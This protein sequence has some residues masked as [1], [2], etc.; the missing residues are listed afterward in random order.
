MQDHV[1]SMSSRITQTSDELRAR[2][3]AAQEELEREQQRLRTEAQKLP[4]ATRESVDSMRRMLAEQMRA[5]DQVQ[6]IAGR[7][8]T[9]ISPPGPAVQQPAPRALP[10]AQPSL[11]AAIAAAMPPPAQPSAAPATG[12]SVGDLLARAS[13]EEAAQPVAEPV[14]QRGPDAGA[15]INLEQIAT[16]LDAQTAGAIWTR[17]RSGQRGILVRSIYTAE[18]RGIFDDV[19]RRYAAD[20]GFRGMIDRFMGEFERELRDVEARDRTGQMLQQHLVSS[21]GRVYLFLAHASGRLN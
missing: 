17:F 18:G 4:D 15:P 16:A 5:L 6:Q 7:A 19:S 2:S 8:Q 13:K 21:G 14:P 3:R 10:A 1:G 12:W 9:D 11:T 20:L